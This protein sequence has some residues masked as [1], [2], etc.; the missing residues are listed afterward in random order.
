VERLTYKDI[1]SYF[2]G[3]KFFCTS[4][5]RTTVVLRFRRV[6]DITDINW[7][8]A[9]IT[10]KAIIRGAGTI[11]ELAG[12]NERQIEQA[13]IDL[14][15]AGVLVNFRSLPSNLRYS[16]LNGVPEAD[17]RKEMYHPAMA[18][19]VEEMLLY[20]RELWEEGI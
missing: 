3:F 19:F 2:D 7:L 12:T 4:H 16:M 13:R 14:Q 9:T 11:K 10:L 5:P 15:L 17:M 1:S 18:N 8:S 6:E 20:A